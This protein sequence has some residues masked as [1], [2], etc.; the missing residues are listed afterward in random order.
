MRTRKHLSDDRLVEVCVDR[1]PTCD[2][3]AHFT[4]CEE[5]RTRRARLDLLLDDVQHAVAS[6]ADA[7][8]SEHRLAAQHAKILHRLE[9]DGRPARVIAFPAFQGSERRPLRSRPAA[10]WIAGAAAAGLIVGMLAGHLAHDMPLGRPSRQPVVQATAARSKPNPV[11]RTVNTTVSEEE[12]LGAIESAIDG[13][14][15]AVLRPLNELTPQ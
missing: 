2:E 13:P 3:D 4:A 10:R 5:C 1:A 7:A 9:Q 6:E 11:F 14:T 12:L 15:L 8:F